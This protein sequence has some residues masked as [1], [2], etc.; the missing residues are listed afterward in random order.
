VH[1]ARAFVVCEGCEVKWSF[2]C[3]KLPSY[4]YDVVLVVIRGSLHHRPRGEEAM[5]SGAGRQTTGLPRRHGFPEQDADRKTC[6]QIGLNK[7][8]LKNKQRKR[9]KRYSNVQDCR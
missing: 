9:R 1:V 2:K 7:R 4:H 8:E 3:L 6:R 5:T